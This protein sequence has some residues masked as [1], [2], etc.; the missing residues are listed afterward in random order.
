MEIWFVYTKSF[1]FKKDFIAL[2][3]AVLTLHIITP[4]Y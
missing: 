1:F 2:H 4:F 3:L